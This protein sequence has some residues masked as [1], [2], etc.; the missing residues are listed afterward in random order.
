MPSTIPGKHQHFT[1]GK[2]RCYFNGRILFDGDRFTAGAALRIEIYYTLNF[3][4]FSSF[5][6]TVL[7][8]HHTTS[9]FLFSF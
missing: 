1:L 6:Q 8:G 4:I 7:V 9:L 5:P 2:S 3:H